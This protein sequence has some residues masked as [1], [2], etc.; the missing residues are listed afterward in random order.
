MVLFFL[1]DAVLHILLLLGLSAQDTVVS[2]TAML[3]FLVFRE[4]LASLELAF[5]DEE[6][7]EVKLQTIQPKTRSKCF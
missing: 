7:M 6:H 5:Q 1:S 2:W 3:P 4:K